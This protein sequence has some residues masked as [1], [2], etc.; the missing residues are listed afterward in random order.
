[1]PHSPK[2]FN[3]LISL[4]ESLLFRFTIFLSDLWITSHQCISN[5]ANVCHNPGCLV[6]LILLFGLY[7]QFSLLYIFVRILPKPYM[8]FFKGYQ[9]LFLFFF[10]GFNTISLSGQEV[11]AFSHPAVV[12]LA[13]FMPSITLLVSHVASC[14]SGYRGTLPLFYI[15]VKPTWFLVFITSRSG[16]NIILS[17][18][19]GRTLYL[20]VLSVLYLVTCGPFPPG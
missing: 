20:A 18:G 16:R 4:I 19:P 12:P 8:F 17:C 3:H 9:N 11:L 10:T 13:S 14:C 6:I 15:P 7:L 1:M 2:W 5:S